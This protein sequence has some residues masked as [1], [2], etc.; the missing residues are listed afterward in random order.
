MADI[1][2]FEE[3]T[4]DDGEDEAIV[5]DTPEPSSDE[6]E[7]QKEE[8]TDSDDESVALPDEQAA[9]SDD[10]VV[11]PE[12][13]AKIK[14]LEKG[15]HQA[16]RERND[17]QREAAILAQEL[18]AH[19]EY[20]Q[21]LQAQQQQQAQALQVPDTMPEEALGDPVVMAQWVTAKA[22][23]EAQRIQQQTLA[24][25]QQAE[26]RREMEEK[27][28]MRANVID[29]AIQSKGIA[30]QHEFRGCLY[31][32]ENRIRDKDPAIL[33]VLAGRSGPKRDNAILSLAQQLY[34]RRVGQ[35]TGKKV[36]A[37]VNRNQNISKTGTMPGVTHRAGAGEV[38]P[39]SLR[40][41]TADYFKDRKTPYN[42]VEFVH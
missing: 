14:N 13:N 38:Q 4:M 9:L 41:F 37:V 28:R 15:M 34:E 7:E 6:V 31:E 36:T 8:A 24:Y 2:D 35:T 12:E 11:L 21:Q 20:L 17:A 29:S 39:K 25:Q 22:R 23:Q 16:F 10:D 42:T 1:Y 5:D 27:E 3:V 32:I 26:Q 40:Q 30:L 33:T 18:Q 19:R